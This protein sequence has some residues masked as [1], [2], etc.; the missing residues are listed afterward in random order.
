MGVLK[1]VLIGVGAVVGLG[2]LGLG[3]FVFVTARAFDASM[4]K[5]YDQKPLDQ[6]KASKDEA[7]IARG[8]H[9][10]EA[11]AGC[12]S[13]DCHGTDLAGGKEMS[14]GP[15]GTLT[16]PNLTGGGLG[17][18]Y[19]DGEFARI[20][21]FGIKKNGKSAVFMP[22]QDFNW[23]NDED[24]TALVSF[25]RSVPN[26]DKPNGAMKLG[27]LAKILDRQGALPID[28]ARKIDGKVELA[29]KPEPTAAYGKFLAKS[30]MGCHGEG[31]SGGKIPGAPGDLPV[32]LNLTPDESGLKG[33]TQED[34]NKLLEKGDRKNG[35]KLHEFMPI[36]NYG[37][38]DATEKTALFAYLMSLPPK[39]FGGR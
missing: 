4:D 21:R 28:V 8:K 27:L 19:T 36:E 39:P 5:V 34:F 26:V 24:L 25:L 23:M 3:G 35:K 1:K 16:G 9:I 12:T 10:A 15:L 13:K 30:C 29:G 18:A 7:V 2:A 37:L 32:P 14:M 33:W 11:V 17:A 6:I 20:V 38:M 22:A 31:L